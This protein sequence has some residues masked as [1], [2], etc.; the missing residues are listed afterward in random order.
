MHRFTPLAWTF[1]PAATRPGRESVPA[2]SFVASCNTLKPHHAMHTIYISAEDNARLRMLLILMPFSREVRR[3]A[4][5]LRHELDRAVLIRTPADHPRVIRLGTQFEFHDLRSGDR[6]AHR[7]CLPEDLPRLRNG[8]SILTRF[9]AAV[10]GCSVGDEVTWATP[11]GTRRILIMG[12]IPPESA[13]TG[14]LLNPEPE[15]LS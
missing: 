8:L 11:V 6:G 7:L 3:E 12:A 10:M 1:S 4:A 5:F 14:K 2:C 9:G 13:A 15:P